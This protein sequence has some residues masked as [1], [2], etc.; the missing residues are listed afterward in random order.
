[1]IMPRFGRLRFVL[2]PTACLSLAA[3]P[4][5]QQL[6][7]GALIVGE[8]L[9]RSDTGGRSGE[10]GDSNCLYGEWRLESA[11][12]AGGPE[13]LRFGPR[14]ISA[15][16]NSI[17]TAVQYGFVRGRAGAEI[18]TFN[19]RVISAPAGV[20][21]SSGGRL[22]LTMLTNN[23]LSYR[24]PLGNRAT[25]RKVVSRRNYIIV[26]ARGM[27]LRGEHRSYT[28][29]TYVQ[30]LTVD[31]RTQQTINR[32]VFGFY[33]RSES[34]DDEFSFYSVQPGQVRNEFY[35]VNGNYIGWRSDASIAI[36]IS[37][38]AMARALAA[39]RTW[40]QKSGSD[41]RY[42]YSL[43]GANCINFVYEVLE[44][45]QD[46]RIRIS[47][48]PARQVAVPMEIHSE[49]AAANSAY[50]VDLLRI[51]DEEGYTPCLA[52]K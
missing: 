47:H 35:D 43:T 28:G 31:Y 14:E 45:L 12:S 8:A 15:S 1:M 34:A 20:G 46:D 25:F 22:I 24:D 32:G 37:D 39:V 11:S 9:N 18:H 19:P 26:H 50:A 3:C 41:Q 52:W 7:T 21:P 33:P 29:H 16:N 36:E 38:E 44:S 23:V 13:T 10:I 49:F 6:A 27:A 17:Q 2:I 40:S 5:L 4:K 51:Y 30:L 48:V 42:H